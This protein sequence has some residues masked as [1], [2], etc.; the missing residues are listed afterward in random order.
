VFD[1]NIAK[2]L[3]SIEGRLENIQRGLAS[4]QRNTRKYGELEMATLQQVLQEVN[5]ETSQID[6]LGTLIAGLR[7]QVQDV[8]SGASLPPA[9]QNQIDQIFARA[10]ANKQKIADAL[11]ANTEAPAT[12]Q[13]TS[14]D[15]GGATG[16]SG[17]TG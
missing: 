10:E 12:D 1:W 9:V 16:A 3:S 15:Q 2:R 17:Q 13:S 4:L 14:S 5:D 11:A 7:K 6:G 8:T